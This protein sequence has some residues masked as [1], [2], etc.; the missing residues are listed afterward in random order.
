V[1]WENDGRVKSLLT[2]V[3]VGLKLFKGRERRRKKKREKLKNVQSK[4]QVKSKASW[5]NERG[6]RK[7]SRDKYP[8]GD[9]GY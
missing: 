1:K 9:N 6:L 3:V 5:V 8:Q 2:S 4:V 7:K